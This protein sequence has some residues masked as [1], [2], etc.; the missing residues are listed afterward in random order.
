M[1]IVYV[2]VCVY[3]THHSKYHTVMLEGTKKE[4]FHIANVS[5]VE[6]TSNNQAQRSICQ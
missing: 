4:N 1:Y 6:T 3:I 5:S 2:R